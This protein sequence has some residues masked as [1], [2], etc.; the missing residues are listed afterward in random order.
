MAEMARILLDEKE[1]D[2]AVLRGSE[3]EVGIDIGSLR[4]DTGAIT[5]DPG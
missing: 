3:G 5:V 2:L 1:I 4:R